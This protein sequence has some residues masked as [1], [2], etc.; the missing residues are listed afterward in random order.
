MV[1]C[2]CNVEEY[3]M[4]IHLVR[5]CCRCVLVGHCQWNGGEVGQLV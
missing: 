2:T 3:E 4:G 5:L 1:A